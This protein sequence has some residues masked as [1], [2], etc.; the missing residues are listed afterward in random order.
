[1]RHTSLARRPSLTEVERKDYTGLWEILSAVFTG[2]DVAA[3]E[4]AGEGLAH[5]ARDYLLIG[6]NEPGVQNVIR[7]LREASEERA[8]R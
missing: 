1:M 4:R 8:Y 3:L 7:V 6:K 2:E 5:T